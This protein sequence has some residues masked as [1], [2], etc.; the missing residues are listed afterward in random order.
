MG[1]VYF[2]MENK[3]CSHS[4]VDRERHFEGLRLV[5]W[6]FCNSCGKFLKEV[7]LEDIRN[8]KSYN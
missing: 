3:T 6:H 4:Y 2:G 5:E 7:V 1:V 8:E